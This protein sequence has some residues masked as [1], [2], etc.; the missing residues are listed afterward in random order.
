M[1]GGGSASGPGLPPFLS[2]PQ[3]ICGEFLSQVGTVCNAAPKS[4]DAPQLHVATCLPA[5]DM[6]HGSMQTSQ[7][8]RLRP[9]TFSPQPL[10]CP[11]PFRNGAAVPRGPARNATPLSSPSSHGPLTQALCHSDLSVPEEPSPPLPAHGLGGAWPKSTCSA[12]RT[13]VHRCGRAWLIS[14][15]LREIFGVLRPLCSQSP[16]T[17]KIRF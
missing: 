11:Q 12:P 1:G 13:S 14:R 16:H 6:D 17:L 7:V 4:R 3:A 9:A 10:P 5:P 8:C 15:Q 2:T